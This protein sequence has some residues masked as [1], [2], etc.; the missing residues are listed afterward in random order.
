[1]R[2]RWFSTASTPLRWFFLSGEA[3]ATEADVLAAQSLDEALLAPSVASYAQRTDADVRR[4]RERRGWT[5]G[6]RESDRGLD[7]LELGNLMGGVGF[8]DGVA[9]HLFEGALDGRMS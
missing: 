9:G 2:R 6:W 5:D 1:M 4:L 3:Q 8:E 7:G